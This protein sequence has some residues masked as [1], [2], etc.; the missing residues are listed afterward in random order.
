MDIEAPQSFI[1]REECQKAASQNGFRRVLGEEAGWRAFASTTAHG[2]IYLAAEGSKGPWFL[3]TDHAG[4]VAEL[5]WPSASM[6]GPGTRRYSFD[7]LG[8]L[9]A[10]LNR[11]YALAI[12]LP[13][14]PLREFERRVADLPRATEVE[15]LVVQRIGQE[16]FRDRLMDYW[17]GRCPLTEISDPALLRASHIIP[18]A[19]CESDAERLDVHNG[20]LLSALWDAAFD[21]ALVTFSDAGEPEFS[22]ALSDQ[23]RAE[24]RWSAPISLT[25]EHRRRLRS[26]R[27]R[28]RSQW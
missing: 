2:T 4:V 25:D 13:E 5:D 9:Y 27:E 28:A 21:R 16:I 12:S 26:H 15:R 22:S 19:D 7:A 6:P 14:A 11:V 3:A 18:W 20:L 10:A 23:A 24:L 1:V 17:Q 8:E